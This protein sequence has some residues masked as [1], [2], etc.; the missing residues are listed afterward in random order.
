M[1]KYVIYG[2]GD[3]GKRILDY[4]GTDCIKFYIDASPEK[5]KNGYLGYDVYSLED[6]VSLIGGAPI[7]IALSDEKVFQV[8]KE[9][10][11]QKLCNIYSFKE[12]QVKK[13]REKID[14]RMDY[15]G[16]YRK[17]VD[18][19][20][21]NSILGKGIINNSK[22]KKAYPEVT[23]YYIP[24]LL[25]WGYR[26]IA[27]GYAKWLCD[28]QHEDGS[29][30]DTEDEKPYIFDSAQ[31]IKGLIAIRKIMP[32][33]DGYIIK[34][35]DWILSNMTKEGRLISPLENAWGDGKTFSELIHTYCIS[36]IR[37]AGKL[38]GRADYVEKSD[39]IVD[40]YITKCKDQIVNFDLLSHFYAY[41]MEAMLDI[42]QDDIAREAM[43]KMAAIQK[44]TGAVPAYNDVD[45]VCST[46][47][48]Q[49]SIVWFRLGKVDNGL[50][51]FEYACKL[52]NESGGW[53]GSYMSEENPEEINTYFPD[54]EISWANKYFLDALYYRNKTLFDM[55]SPIFGDT[56]RDN[57][58]RYCCVR[59]VVSKLQ[60]SELNILDVG[61]GKGRYLKRLIEEFPNNHYYAVDLSLPVME[62]INLPGVEKT[63]GTLTEIPY[64]D[65]YFD[66]VYAC[67]A[68]EHAVD[69]KSA[70]REMCR[71]VK[72][73][74][75]VVIVDKNKDMLGYFPIEEWEQWFDESELR[76]ELL[77]YCVDVEVIREIPF[78][79]MSANG[80]FYSWIG[81]VK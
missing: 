24:T 32:E 13:T 22:L 25:R 64:E 35:C 76:N 75:M 40:Y 55:Q 60:K 27:E 46:G 78:D 7:V 68:L 53:F 39:L 33:V 21:N 57:D 81:K 23:G 49:L 50:R 41:V 70:V 12:I 36:P 61:C 18:W 20:K 47:L 14:N 6:A 43:E 58:G 56:I 44:N 31:I 71:V 48:F 77:L 62:F 66:V 15:I 3:Y 8:K 42:G 29:W 19:I 10:E 11:K 16:L 63:Q 69:I 45:W 54:S 9:I 73:G 1:D 38:L 2:A 26:D 37:D 52:Q 5:Q 28:I 67:E 17:A 74:G 65:E 80:L 4:I 30:Y 72:R 79:D 51:A 59:N 34:G